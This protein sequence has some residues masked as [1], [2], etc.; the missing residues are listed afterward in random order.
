[1]VVKAF[2]A[3][4]HM[5]CLTAEQRIYAWGL[6]AN[7]RLGLPSFRA[8]SKPNVIKFPVQLKALDGKKVDGLSAGND[9]TFAW[10]SHTS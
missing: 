4:E 5:F 3:S 8:D 2:C 7:G 10:S 6:N 9:H 1:M